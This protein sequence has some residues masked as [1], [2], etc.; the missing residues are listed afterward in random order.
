[1]NTEFTESALIRRGVPTALIAPITL[2]IF[3]N[4]RGTGLIL[5]RSAHVVHV[6]CR[7]MGPPSTPGSEDMRRGRGRV[8]LHI[9]DGFSSRLERPSA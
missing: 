9:H 4:S 7:M 2:V 3:P 5:E 6:A 8:N 1:M